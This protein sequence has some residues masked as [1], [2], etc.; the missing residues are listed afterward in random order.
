MLS[1]GFDKVEDTK[2]EI[3]AFVPV[4]FAVEDVGGIFGEAGGILATLTSKPVNKLEEILY[5]VVLWIVEL[6]LLTLK[7]VAIPIHVR[8]VSYV[9]SRSYKYSTT[10][11]GYVCADGYNLYP[12]TKRFI[13]FLQIK[14]GF[15]CTRGLYIGGRRA[16]EY[17]GTNF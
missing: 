12:L 2:G 13:T 7:R 17:Q 4:E 6:P 15:L 9:F 10:T 1:W 3:T 16:I 5:D 14:T 11:S 8:E